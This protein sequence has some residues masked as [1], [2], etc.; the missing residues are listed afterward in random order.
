[1]KSNLIDNIYGVGGNKIW[2][3]I[4]E[5]DFSADT[6]GWNSSGISSGNND[7]ILGEDDCFKLEVS[8]IVLPSYIMSSNKTLQGYTVGKLQRATGK[9]YVPSGQSEITGFSVNIH[10]ATTEASQIYS[11]LGQN[12]S[13]VEFETTYT[14]A[15]QSIIFIRPVNSNGVEWN[16]YAYLTSA[17]NGDILY[18]K[19]IVIED[20]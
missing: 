19:D 20:Y 7:G 14:L 1:M 11:G 13:W 2:N 12:G 6:D 8:G 17:A 18:W 4:Y 9:I 3:T 16:D 5:S 10:P 15:N